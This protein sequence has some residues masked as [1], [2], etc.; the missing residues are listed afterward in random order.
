VRAL[1][2]PYETDILEISFDGLAAP[3]ASTSHWRSTLYA[4]LEGVSERLQISRDDIDG[5]LHPTPGGRTALVIFDAVPGGAGSATR[6]AR[7]FDDVLEA[8][9]TRVSRCDCGE[10]TSCYGC[11]RGYRNQP[12]HDELRRGAALRFLAPLVP[13]RP[14]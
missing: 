11:L 12:F 2:H 14:Q 4:L 13:A 8:A 9:L 1:A 7:S 5:T 3:L 10:E 6:I